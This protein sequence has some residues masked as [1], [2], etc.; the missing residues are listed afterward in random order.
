MLIP[1][2]TSCSIR[3]PLRRNETTSV[4][5]KHIRMVESDDEV[6]VVD[7]VEFEK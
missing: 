6:V 4:W 7:L 1:F 3:F 2:L 5:G